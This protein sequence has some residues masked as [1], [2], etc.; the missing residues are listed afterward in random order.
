MQISILEAKGTI[1]EGNA[2]EAILPTSEGEMCVLD[3]HQPFLVKL[4]KGELHFPGKK[5][6]IKY[7]IAFMKG[8]SLKV[9]VE[10]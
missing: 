3:F 10:T 5:I 4:K 6:A 2:K 1:W 9:F 8:N 7:G